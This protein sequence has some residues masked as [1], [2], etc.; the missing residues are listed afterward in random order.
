MKRLIL[1]LAAFGTFAVLASPAMA[2]NPWSHC[3]TSYGY[4]SYGISG[5]GVGHAALHNEL[6]RRAFERELIHQ[7][8]HRYPLTHFQHNQLIRSLENDAR[9]DAQLHRVYHRST[10][11]YLTPGCNTGYGSGISIGNYGYGSGFSLRIGF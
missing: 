11:S 2:G 9:R 8:A 6:D 10:P 4:S 7:D 3:G 1:T 5:Y